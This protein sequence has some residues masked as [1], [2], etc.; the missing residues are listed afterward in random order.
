MA[1]EEDVVVVADLHVVPG[2]RA[3]VLFLVHD[4]FEELDQVLT[5]LIVCERQ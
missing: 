2:D 3:D 1:T 5:T 4:A